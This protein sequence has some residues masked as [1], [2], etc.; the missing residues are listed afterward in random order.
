MQALHSGY[1][2]FGRGIAALALS[3]SLAAEAEAAQ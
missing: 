2:F 3:L 1:R